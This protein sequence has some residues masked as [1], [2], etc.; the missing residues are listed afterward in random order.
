MLMHSWLQQVLVL[1]VLT[2]AQ[3]PGIVPRSPHPP[4]DVY[5]IDTSVSA[6]SGGRRPQNLQI[7]RT[8]EVFVNGL[9]VRVKYCET[10][11]VYRP[12]RC[13]HCSVCDNCVERFDHHCPWVGQCIGKVCFCFLALKILIIIFLLSNFSSFGCSVTI[14][15]SS[16]SFLPQHFC[17]SSCFQC[18]P[19][20]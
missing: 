15:T 3:D 12:P 7:P 5:A 8:K 13:S 11:M 2:S 19:Y 9:P 16:F 18:Q 6:E 17:A 1:L 14:V 20:T 4:E 10:C